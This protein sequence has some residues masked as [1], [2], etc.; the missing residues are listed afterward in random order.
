MRFRWVWLALIVVLSVGWVVPL[1]LGI[2][3]TL[4][5]LK[6]EVEP[7]LYGRTTINSFPFVSFARD[8]L[9]LAIAWLTLVALTWSTLA[10]SRLL[11]TRPERRT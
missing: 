2:D 4:S 3:T 6:M 9:Q 11:R 5:Y 1:W 7:R 10:A 8:C